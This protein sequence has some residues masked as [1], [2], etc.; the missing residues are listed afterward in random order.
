MELHESK[1]LNIAPPGYEKAFD[2]LRDLMN[3][4]HGWADPLDASRARDVQRVAE[5][6]DRAAGRDELQG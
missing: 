4:T 2:S 5:A 3:K 6:P 1:S